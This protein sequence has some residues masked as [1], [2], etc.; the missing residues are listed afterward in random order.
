MDKE[1]L[2]L[3]RLL[4]ARLERISVDSYWA[5]RA[6]GVR[7]LLLRALEKLETGHPSQK[8]RLDTLIAKGFDILEKAAIEKSL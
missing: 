2:E 3:I 1:P 5:H 8:S 4:L 6:S 7:G